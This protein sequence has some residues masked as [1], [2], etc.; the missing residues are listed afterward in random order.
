M[1][2]RSNITDSPEKKKKKKN[3]NH[4]KKEDIFKASHVRRVVIKLSYHKYANN[5][6]WQQ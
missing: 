1:Y 4:L 3:S 2:V 5:G 6:K